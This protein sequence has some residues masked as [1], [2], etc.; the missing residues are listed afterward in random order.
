MEVIRTWIM[1][2]ARPL[3]KALYLYHFET[4]SKEAVIHELQKYQNTD[5]GFGHGLEPDYLN[6][7][8]TPVAS[9]FAM[10]IIEHLNLEK[11]H[12]LVVSLID[13]FLS[14][15]DQLDWFYFIKVKSNNDYPHAPW[16]HYKKGSEIDGYNP[17]AAILGFVYKYIDRSHPM[18]FEVE[19]A[20]DQAIKD[21]M[22]MDILEMH[23]LRCFNELYQLIC[24]HIDCFNLRKRL[25]EL[26]N[27]AIEKD[28]SKWQT[29]YC[30]KPS[31]V[32]VSM[33]TPGVND[34]MGLIHQ[35]IKL[36]FENRNQEGVFDIT[37]DWGQYQ[38]DAKKARRAWQGVVAIKMLLIKKEFK[39]EF[40]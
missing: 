15:K 7:N 9:Q 6:P 8:S 2:N 17:T 11:D 37:W 30:A 25:V 23:E 27:K 29:S 13:Y 31:Q 34:M 12:P 20:I 4:G 32:I 24:E 36:M 38:E 14:T 26:N 19:K 10:N 22:V 33:H 18:Y 35:E 1:E 39:V 40:N 3:E 16:W 21:L 28:V 5:G